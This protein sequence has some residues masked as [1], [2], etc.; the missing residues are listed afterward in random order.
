[1]IE[2]STNALASSAEPP[3]P[4]AQP[5]KPPAK[6]AKPPA[7]PA[8]PSKVQASDAPAPKGQAPDAQAPDAQAPEKVTDKI[9]AL[10]EQVSNTVQSKAGSEAGAASTSQGSM[11]AKIG[12]FLFAVL[13][14][15]LFGLAL[16]KG[17]KYAV[18]QPYWK[19]IHTEITKNI[20]ISFAMM[21]LFFVVSVI[22]YVQDTAS[23]IQNLFVLLLF[24]FLLS[25]SAISLGIVTR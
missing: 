15:V 2:M 20:G 13:S 11:K 5:P 25:F 24:V 9:I 8:N 14:L 10:V 6:P 4:P 16:N 3:K 12:G 17:V 21:F 18:E 1:M 19:V 7:Q 23:G 22:Y